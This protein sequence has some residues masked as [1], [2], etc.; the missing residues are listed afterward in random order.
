MNSYQNNYSKKINSDLRELTKEITNIFSFKEEYE[1]NLIL[2]SYKTNLSKFKDELDLFI[3]EY[4]FEE[5]YIEFMD[6][7]LVCEKMFH[8]KPMGGES[9]E[10]LNQYL[11]VIVDHMESFSKSKDLYSFFM[12]SYIMFD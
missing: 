11:K 4:G 12:D 5:T 9:F 7:G 10:E 1:S 3:S 2:D 6:D 8:I